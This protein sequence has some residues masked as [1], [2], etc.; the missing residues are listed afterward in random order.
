MLR[1][2]VQRFTVH[3]PA[4]EG[5]NP[6]V[7]R[8]NDSTITVNRAVID[9]GAYKHL[10]YFWFPMRGRVLTNAWQMKWWYNFWDALTR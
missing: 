9:K 1:Q 2:R 4:P 7:Q 6:G 8:F 3:S 5:F 10:S